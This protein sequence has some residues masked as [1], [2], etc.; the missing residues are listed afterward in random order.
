MVS[1][2]ADSGGLGFGFKWD[3]GW[4][5]DTLKY[6][7]QDPFFRKY[8]HHELT[9]RMIYAFSEN[10]VLSLSHDEVVHGKGSLIEKM[11]GD[12]WQKFANLRLLYAYMWAQPGKKLLFM[13]GEFG[14]WTEWSHD[15]GLDWALLDHEKHAQLRMLIG[16]LNHL[17]RTERALHER[18]SEPGSFE[19]I[20]CCD[21]EKNALSFIRNPSSQ[22]G[23]LMVLCNFSPVPR[24]NYRVGAPL[25]GMWREVLNTDAVQFGGSGIGNY[26]GVQTVPIPLHGRLYSL[27]LTLP[28][29]G[30]VFL[31]WDG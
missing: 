29:L 24:Q 30:V 13:G 15:G 1:K 26:G 16:T 12:Y 21:A 18:E 28:P 4:M 7:A 6:V 5:H 9:F 31:R 22:P 2:P 23:T 8:H 27:T 3:M 25:G 20:D 19:W 14:Q 10:F 17:Y 11:P